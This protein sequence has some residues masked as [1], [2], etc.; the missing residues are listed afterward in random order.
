MNARF[1]QQLLVGENL[2]TFLFI[3]K[4]V[5]E[6]ESLYTVCILNDDTTKPFKMYF[7]DDHYEVMGDNVPAEIKGM[8]FQL[9]QVINNYYVMQSL[10]NSLNTNSSSDELSQVRI[11]KQ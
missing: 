11:N 5:S 10:L 4:D 2:R 1:T 7:I 3:E 9:N 8:S 6:T